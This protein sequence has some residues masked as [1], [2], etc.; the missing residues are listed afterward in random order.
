MTK[1]PDTKSQDF[2]DSRT[3]L[4]CSPTWQI[5]LQSESRRD[6]RDLI[7]MLGHGG[8]PFQILGQQSCGF[9]L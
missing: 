3:S 9:D 4:G 7:S 1:D 8:N 2:G 6:L 5:Y